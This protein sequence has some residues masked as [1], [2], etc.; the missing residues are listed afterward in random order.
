V[1]PVCRVKYRH[2]AVTSEPLEDSLYGQV[3]EPLVQSRLA[4]VVAIACSIRGDKIRLA[5]GRE[6]ADTA[7]NAPA[8]TCRASH[9]P[10]SH[11]RE[12]LGCWAH[13]Q[14]LSM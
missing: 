2:P 11:G 5:T 8:D 4:E 3:D 9:Y 6:R 12:Y 13:S 14:Y 7:P 10:A 1:R